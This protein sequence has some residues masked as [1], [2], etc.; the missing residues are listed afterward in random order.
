VNFL[1]HCGAD[2]AFRNAQRQTPLH[3]AAMNGSPLILR[4][5]LDAGAD[6][7]AVDEDG[8]QAVHAAAQYGETLALE[9]LVAGGAS[10]MA[11]DKMQRTPLHWAAYNN[12]IVAT[13]WLVRQVHADLFA[14]DAHGRT[15][16]HWAAAKGHTD[17]VRFLIEE[18]GE[19]QARVRDAEGKTPEEFAR[20][21]NPPPVQTLRF[22]QAVREAHSSLWGSVFFVLEGW[23]CAGKHRMK[24]AST[25][26][27]LWYLFIVLV[28]VIHDSMSLYPANSAGHFVLWAAA[29]VSVLTWIGTRY[30]NPGF[31][32]RPAAAETASG[33]HV[34]LSP[35]D[36]D[37]EARR[38]SIIGSAEL[39]PGQESS[40]SYTGAGAGVPAPGSSSG[41]PPTHSASETSLANSSNAESAPPLASAPRPPPPPAAAA[42][43]ASAAAAPIPLVTDLLSDDWCVTCRVIRPLR[44]KHCVH[45]DRC[46]DEADHHCPWISS[47]VGKGNARWFFFFLLTTSVALVAFI[48]NAAVSLGGGEGGAVSV[49]L[50]LH[51]LVFLVFVGLVLAKTVL[52]VSVNLTTHERVN[53]LRKAYFRDEHNHFRNPFDRGC[54]RN[55]LFFL[56][57]ASCS[58]SEAPVQLAEGIS[59]HPAAAAAAAARVGRRELLELAAREHAELH[60][61][62]LNQPATAPRPPAATEAA[63]GSGGADA[64]SAAAQ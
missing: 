52:N 60:Q 26:A 32:P 45:C 54:L 13:R 24:R 1:L 31:V 36:G 2:V 3:W 30:T 8:F 57:C 49:V 9:V 59:P 55:W 37:V 5:L 58:S 15:P 46:V 50:L 19:E 48:V 22:L 25:W 42:A 12:R 16:L 47:C 39:L 14:R 11:R 21:R 33:R 34:Q 63:G 23:C 4:R 6:L 7:G 44:A 40:E 20:G 17:L 27:S 53:L 18:G 38:P 28:S 10:A 43:P 56:G 29:V 41:A 64:R 62:D 35:E 51:N 61:R